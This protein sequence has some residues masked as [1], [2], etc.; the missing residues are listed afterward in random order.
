MKK[1]YV[2]P[3]LQVSEAEANEMMA[4]SLLNGQANPDAE[5]LI[6]ED[7]EWNIWGDEE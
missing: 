6:R 7:T 2:M 3:A 1:R 4:V 5:V